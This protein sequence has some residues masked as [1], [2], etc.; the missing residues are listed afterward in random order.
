MHGSRYAGHLGERRTLAR[1]RSRFYCPGMS[2]DVHT[3][4]AAGYPLQRVGMDILGPLE[5]T[6][7]GNRYVLVLTDYFTK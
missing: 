7:S 2:G 4:I 3:D 1:V 5:K 6:P